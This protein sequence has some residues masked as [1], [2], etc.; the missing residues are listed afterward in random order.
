MADDAG[1]RPGRRPPSDLVVWDLYSGVGSIGLSLAAQ[2][3]AVLAIEAV[4]AA[5]ADARENAR[6]NGIDNVSVLEGDVAKMLHETAEGVRRLPEDLER[7]D[8]VIVDPPRAGLTKKAVSRVAEICAPRMVYVSCNPSTMA[9]NIAQFGDH[10]YRLER[11]TPV[12]MFPHTPHVEA[13]ALMSRT[14]G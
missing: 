5:V 1:P 11:V 10:G 2:V 8:V 13:V 4:P 12:D 14:D 6:L 9:P 7:P 3:R